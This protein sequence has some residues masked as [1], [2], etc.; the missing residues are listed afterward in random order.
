MLYDY[1]IIYTLNGLSQDFEATATSA[2]RA[3]EDLVQYVT[4]ELGFTSAEIDQTQ[5][6]CQGPALFS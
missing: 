6:I 3:L 5:V 2:G 1:L 4:G